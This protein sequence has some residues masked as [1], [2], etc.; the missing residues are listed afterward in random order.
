MRCKYLIE[1]LK[2]VP[3]DK[4]E[5]QIHKEYCLENQRLYKSTPNGKKWVVPRNARRQVVLHFHDGTGHLSLDKTL[6]AVSKL[7]WFP[8]M[9]RYVKKFISAC[10]PC[11]YN[12][13]PGGKRPGYLHPIEKIDTPFDTLHVDHL[14]PFVTSRLKNQYLIVIVESFTKFVFLKPVRSTKAAPLVS[15]LDNVIENFGVPR[16]I[17]TDR[18]SCYTSKQFEQFC[19][20]LNIKHVLNAT[21]TPR[22]NGQVE[23]YNRTIL[24]S[25]SAST[26][27][28]REMGHKRS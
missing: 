8:G 26:E 17:I 19:K 1:A 23:R 14:G 4:E 13:E 3:I 10:L 21:A 25:L 15:F 20:N 24:S 28:G 27:D 5:R 11:L 6:S 18:G 12:K 22:A 7:Y 2:K 16:R 9:R